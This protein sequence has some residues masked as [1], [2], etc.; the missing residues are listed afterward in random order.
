MVGFGLLLAISGHLL[1]SAATIATLV[2]AL[3]LASNAKFAVLGEPLLFSDLALVG[4][5]VRHPQFY[6]SAL[7]FWQILLLGTAAAVLPALLAWAF[8]PVATVH[9]AGLL[10][11]AAACGLLVLLLRLPPWRSLPLV[12]DTQTDVVRHGLLATML[13]HWSKWRQTADPPAC[14]ELTL[15]RSGAEIV[16]IIQCESFADPVELFRNPDLTLPGLAMARANALQWGNLNVSGFG[17]YTMRTEY[18]VLFGRS[19]AD[20]GFRCFDP[21]LTAMGEASHALPARLR[22]MGWRSVFIHPHDLGFYGRDRIMPKAGFDEL[23]GEDSFPAPAPGEGRYVTDAELASRIIKV[24]SEANDRTLIYAVSIENHG[25][26]PPDTASD[27]ARQSSAY[28]RLVRKGDAMLSRL[29]LALD[30][31]D[32]PALLVFFGDH[33][34]SIPGL[35]DPGGD[36]HTPYVLLRFGAANGPERDALGPCDLTPAGLHHVLLAQLGG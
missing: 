26:W 35:S 24:A 25:P 30:A 1:L 36:R 34:P 3:A 6:F 19:E 17:A 13:M 23:L 31:L 22:P 2:I 11:A 12:P 18:G 21:F 9:L 16:V 32:R 15:A 10:V 4:A 33:R 8:V 29:L 28:L 5:V 27:G 7:R 20:L 14:K